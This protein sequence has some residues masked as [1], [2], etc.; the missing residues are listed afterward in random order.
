ML[1]WVLISVAV[2]L[3]VAYLGVGPGSTPPIVEDQGRPVPA[4][5]A[6]LRAV[7]IGGLEQW[8]L[9]R[10]HDRSNPVLLWLHGGPGSAQIPIHRAFNQE[11]ERE[12]VVVHGD[13]RGAGKTNHVGFREE[14]MTLE[15]FLADV[16]ELTHDLKVRFVQ[17][18]VFPLAHSWGALLGVY[19]V[20]LYPEDY[21]AFVSVSQPVHARRA[22]EL[23]YTWLQAGVAARV[24]RAQKERF[25]AL[26]SPPFLDHVRYVAFSQLRDEFGE[27][28][29]V[30]IAR[31]AWIALGAEEYA[32]ADYGRWLSGAHRG[33]GPTWE[34]TRNYDLFREV[35]PLDVPVWFLVG[36][37][38]CN[39]PAR[40]VP[41]YHEV[42]TAPRGKHL[43]VL[44]GTAH[45]PHPVPGRSP[46]VSRPPDPNQAGDAPRHGSPDVP[47][48]GDPGARGRWRG[49][50]R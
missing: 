7:E 50:G 47:V 6:E 49:A 48:R 29:N 42:L 5:I 14:T 25:T 33:S 34:E 22:E 9:V 10:G 38:D 28:M 23:S 13:Q 35:P 17:E 27:G 4:G 11:L 31:L 21:H 8:V 12:F 44:D 40:L 24:T 20:Q 19:A 1:N 2:G 30:G 26:V 45:G 15:R 41:E 36:S 37:E 3:V 43:I 18:R 16:R 46:A 32:I 39:T